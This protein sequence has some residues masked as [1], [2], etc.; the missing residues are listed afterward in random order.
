VLEEL[1]NDVEHFGM[2][3]NEPLC[4]NKVPRE[5]IVLRIDNDITKEAFKLKCVN[6][7]QKESNN[8][9]TT[10]DIEMM[11]RYLDEDNQ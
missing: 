7:L 3:K 2:E 4:K 5:G 10:V 1:K 6:Y 11:S 8:I 9:D